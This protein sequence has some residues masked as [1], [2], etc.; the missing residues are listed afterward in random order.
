MVSLGG[1][2]AGVGGGS[3]SLSNDSSKLSS[4]TERTSVGS[5][6]VG[7]DASPGK[8]SS[9]NMDGSMSFTSLRANES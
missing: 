8:S 3:S 5:E 6:R 7:G 9:N 4:D 1:D 2:T